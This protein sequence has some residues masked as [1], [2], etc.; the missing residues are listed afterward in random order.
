MMIFQLDVMYNW[1]YK[2]PQTS[3]DD[4]NCLSVT[5][6]VHCRSLATKWRWQNLRAKFSGKDYNRI[7]TN[8][9]C[10]WLTR[11]ISITRS[12]LNFNP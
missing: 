7:S 12:C 9:V 8:V 11:N 4:K 6:K 10:L 3:V 1:L 5:Q 2:L